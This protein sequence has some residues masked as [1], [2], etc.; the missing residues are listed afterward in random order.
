MHVGQR[1]RDR[2]E[3]LGISQGRLGRH[4]GLTF[5]QVQKYEKGSNRIGA[6]RLYQIAEHLG[7]PPG[8]FFE[9]LAADDQANRGNGTASAAG[10][11]EVRQLT[12]AFG[13][14]GESSTRASVLA[15]VRSL[16][17]EDRDRARR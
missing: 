7:V 3:A 11:D 8:Y 17:D 5:S 6:G 10:P 13:A 12:T 15:L 2:R 14:I 1:L 16:A 4:L 9:G